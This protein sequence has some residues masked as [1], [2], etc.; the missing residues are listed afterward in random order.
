[1]KR[2]TLD[3]KKAWAG[4][5]TAAAVA[6]AERFMQNFQ[7]STKYVM[8]PFHSIQVSNQP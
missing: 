4:A 5:A 6:T 1:M 2:K 3:E 7:S 8:I